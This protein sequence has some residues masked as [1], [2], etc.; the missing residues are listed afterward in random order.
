MDKLYQLYPSSYLEAVY[1]VRTLHKEEKA[2]SLIKKY[3]DKAKVVVASSGKDSIVLQVVEIPP[4]RA[5]HVYS[6]PELPPVVTRHDPR[7][8]SA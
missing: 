8:A 3:V 4:Q 7:R 5:S 2:R 1:L 6:G